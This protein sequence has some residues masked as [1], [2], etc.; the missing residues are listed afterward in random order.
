MI[1][2][3]LAA[4]AFILILLFSSCS[5]TGDRQTVISI[6]SLNGNIFPVQKDSVRYGGISLI[7][8][9]IKEIRKKYGALT[10]VVGN[11]NFIY[12]TREA[13]FTSGRSVIEL[14]NILDFSCLIVGH[15]EFYFGYPEMQDLAN[16]A[17]FPFVSANLVNKDSTRID[18]I[19]PYI[20]LKDGRSAVIGISTGKV[21]RANLEKDVSGIIILDP[22]VTAEKY[23]CELRNK[24]IQNIIIAGDYDCGESSGSNLT[25]SETDR[26]FAIENISMFLTTTEGNR[27]CSLHGKKPI[28]NCGI[29]GYEMVSFVIDRGNVS[30]T[31]THHVSSVNVKP[32]IYISDKMADIRNMI[33]KITG[34]VL[35]TSADDIFHSAGDKFVSETYLGNFIS[36]I[37]RGYTKTD[38]FLMNSGKIRNGFEKGPI[39]LGD[40]YNIMPYEGNLVSVNMTGDQITAVLESSCAFKMSKS[41]LQVSGISFTFDSSKKPGTRVIKESIKVN[42]KALDKNMVYSVSLT[43][44][45]YQGGDSYN[46]FRD[47]GVELTVVHQKQMREII[48]DYIVS[49]GTVAKGTNNRITDVKAVGI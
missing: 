8:S 11:S 24:G 27:S 26:L 42:G 1:T 34:K 40:L 25:P 39:T 17:N 49:K 30:E 38:I 43:D 19:K 28:L 18:F 29:N 3:L 31:N 35:G 33:D 6:S 5:V 32:D 16:S 20:I 22:A 37:M 44:Y 46:E 4:S 10:D 13:Y 2:K 23:V 45:I 21:I 41:F 48:K 14:M 9:K 47:M 7:S 12:G 36:D 15:R